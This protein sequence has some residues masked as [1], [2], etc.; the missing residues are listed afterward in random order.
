MPFTPK[1][2]II[3][4]ISLVVVSSFSLVAAEGPIEDTEEHTPPMDQISQVGYDTGLV[5]D[6]VRMD[7][8]RL[9]DGTW[10]VIATHP[11]PGSGAGQEVTDATGTLVNRQVLSGTY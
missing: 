2:G 6:L 10:A 5:R 9:A 7:L 4:M 8:S 11:S 1:L 3:A